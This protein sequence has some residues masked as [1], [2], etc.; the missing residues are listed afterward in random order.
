MDEAIPQGMAQPGTEEPDV[1][2]STAAL[3]KEW[4][5]KVKAAKD[6]P[7]TKVAFK[8]MKQNMAFAARG[9]DKEWIAAGKYVVPIINRHINQAVAQL[10]AKNPTVVAKRR[11]KLLYKLWDGKVE[12]L[13]MAMETAIMGDPNAL[14]LIEEVQAGEQYKLMVDRIARTIEELWN[15]YVGEQSTNFKQQLKALVRRTKVCG[16]GYVKIGFQRALEARPEVTARIDDVTSKITSVEGILKSV[17][18]DD[19]DE[20]SARMAELKTLLADLQNQEMMVVREGVVFDFPRSNEIII[21]P[22]CRHLKSLVGA[23]WIA[24]E[25]DMTADEVLATYKVKLTGAAQAYRADGEVY[26]HSIATA[27]DRVTYK[28]WEVQDK[29]NRQNLTICDGHTDFLKPPAEPYCAIERFWT[30]FPLVF[31]EIE[32][33]EELYPPSDV[34]LARHIQ[35]EY[36][37]SREALREH[38][39]AARP[40]WVQDGTMEQTELD[41]L[42]NHEAQQIIKVPSLGDGQTIESKLQR[43]PTAPID[44]NLYETEMHFTDLLRVVGAQEA[45]LGGT[46]DSTAT[47]S[48]IAE[49]SRSASLADNVDD[50]DELLTDIA[51]AFGQLALAELSKET[52]VEIVGAGAVWPDMKMTREEIAKDLLLEIKAGSSGRPNKAADL[53]NLERAMPVVLQLPGTK[54]DPF[55]AKYA[56]L[57][58]VDPEE[59]VA[60]GMP[61]IQAMNAMVGKMGG[62][63][64][65]GAAPTG[66]PSTDPNMQGGQGAMNAAGPQQNAQTP[67]PQPAYPAPMPGV[68]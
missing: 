56:M 23:G 8:R 31:N 47:E 44:P 37:R 67:G 66:D 27:K 64:G 26:E 48:S 32:H 40:Y 46:S 55:V 10:Y 33:D 43:G 7:P 2:E 25:F 15:Y 62:A 18:E 16:V 29:K 61:S 51:K 58:D 3:V 9:A 28:V 60:A 53:A 38:R 12:S 57:L 17:A 4:T 59:A 42:S 14:A 54:P 11:R 45:N 68:A 49:Q 21:D 65:P 19:L 22:A 20:D 34:E 63:G 52:V 13:Q 1:E 50:L 30:I 24:Q 6:H 35:L 5:A 39:I 41:K 36:N